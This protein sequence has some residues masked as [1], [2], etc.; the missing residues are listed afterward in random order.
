MDC[1]V[2]DELERHLSDIRSLAARSDLT[3]EERE[4]T[5]RPEKFAIALLKE[6]VES[7]H[8]GKRR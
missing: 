2:K 7:G 4:A 3:P 5:A 8:N 6:H 1:H